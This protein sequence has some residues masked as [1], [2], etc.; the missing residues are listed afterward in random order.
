MA[1]I[2]T[3]DKCE[4]MYKVLIIINEY[5]RHIIRFVANLKKENPGAVI[6]FLTTTESGGLPQELVCNVNNLYN[7]SQYPS[8]TF[9]KRAKA[10]FHIYRVQ[11]LRRVLEEMINDTCRYDVV[12]IHYPR[13]NYYYCIEQLK[14]LSDTILLSPW[15]SDV[16]RI[17]NWERP[18]LKKL[19]AAANNISGVPNRFTRD[20]CKMFDVPFSKVVNLNIGS[21]M[22]D[23]IVEHR[24][25][26]SNEDAKRKIGLQGCYLITCGYNNQPSQRHKEIIKAIS[27]VR[28]ELPESL[29]LV[30]IVTY[31]GSKS[32]LA[33]LKELVKAERLQATFFENYL[34]DEDLFILIQATDVFIHV[35]TTDADAGSVK[36]YILCRKKV[37]NGSWLKYD[38]LLKYPPRPYF[39]VES[40]KTL[41][42]DISIVVRSEKIAISED[43]ELLLRLFGWKSSIKG[44][45]KYYL[46]KSSESANNE[47]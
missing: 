8:N 10:H 27:L 40:M 18:I 36:E 38:D 15:G 1:G 37:L 4:I 19:Y 30:F 11:S 34:T 31:G 17:K 39:E 44:W 21:D 20:F 16:Y 9:L 25:T 13:W 33:E 46:S 35:Q 12:N 7:Y 24:E 45:N 6:D 43:T 29:Q 47:S 23:Y 2:F 5:N 14:K 3:N 41:A 32:Y 28:D 22:I 42:R 26:L